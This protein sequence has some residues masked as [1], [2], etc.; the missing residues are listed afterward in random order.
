MSKDSRS[1]GFYQGAWVTGI[2]FVSGHDL[3]APALVAA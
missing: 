2:V 3:G 1:N